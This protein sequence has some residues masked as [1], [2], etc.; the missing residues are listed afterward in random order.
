MVNTNA[1]TS[2]PM[3]IFGTIMNLTRLKRQNKVFT[4]FIIISHERLGS[5]SKINP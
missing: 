4:N 1:C 2:G 3:V 5:N